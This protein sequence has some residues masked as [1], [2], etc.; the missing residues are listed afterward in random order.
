M[1]VKRQIFN[2]LCSDKSQINCVVTLFRKNMSTDSQVLREIFHKS[3]EVIQPQR[4]IKNEV[5]LCQHHL[6][7]RDQTYEL[8]KPCYIV[9]FGKA[10]YGMAVELE[11]VLGQHLKR[12]IVNVPVG[13]FEKFERVTD[14]K[15]EYVEGAKDNLP[16][17]Q[18]L[19]GAKMI[20]DLVDN[21]QDDLLFVLVSGGG[22]ALLPLPIPPITL[23]EKQNLIRNLAKRGADINEMNCIRKR[24]SIMKGG[25][26]AELAYPCRVVCLVLSDIIGDPLDFIASG[27]TIPNTDSR[28]MALA[29][30]KKYHLY[31]EIPISIKNVIDKEKD[32]TQ[33]PVV[34]GEYE[35]VKTYVIGNNKI[36]TEAAKQEAINKGFQSAII[37][38]QIDGD[39]EKIS[40]IYA[41]LARNIDIAINDNSN[42]GKLRVFLETFSYDLRVEERFVQ[43]LLDMDFN[44]KM[45]L[46]FAGEP[47]VVVKGTGK[48]GR[49]QQLA[50]AFSIEVNKLG[51]KAADISFL[52]CGTDGIDGPTDAAGA[53]A[54]SDFLEHTK[55]INP[56][57]YLENNDAYSFY[58]KFRGGKDLVK[59][60]HTGTNVMDLHLM[61]IH[62]KNT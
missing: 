13:I 41:E 25:G 32:G 55:N 14:S 8:N 57:L 31:N 4:L 48:G 43:E 61:I 2:V 19:N 42:K 10:V 49:N 33:C 3:I 24:I 39:V 9:G 30:L 27:P 23:K 17:E 40:K 20:K 46:I 59:I 28:E 18:A 45:C 22:S 12:G 47:T 21:I 58:Q 62:P 6:T 44:K 15:I 53:V 26:L 60:G 36:A 1:I 7:V 50:L 5:K 51:I 11:Q 34:N 35:H 38:T 29:I 37:S 56:Q 16:D 54:I 52:S